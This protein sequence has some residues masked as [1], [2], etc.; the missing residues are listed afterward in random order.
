MPEPYRVIH[1]LPRVEPDDGTRALVIMHDG[2][3][4]QRVIDAE[5][6][7]DD[8]ALVAEMAA[9]MISAGVNDPADDD[10]YYARGIARCL[11]PIVRA[12]ERAA[13]EKALDLAD[14]L[15]VAHGALVQE[16]VFRVPASADEAH[17][18]NSLAP[19]IR[20]GASARDKISEHRQRM[21]SSHDRG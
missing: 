2:P 6:E 7:A 19:L 11:L 13:A 5:R 9:V 15:I 21:R 10:E 17:W 4:P 16:L 8:K 14:S 18:N 20:D 12:R 1:S 3:L